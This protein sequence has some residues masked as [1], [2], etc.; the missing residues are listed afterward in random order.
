MLNI[1]CGATTKKITKIHAPK[2][3]KKDQDA[4]LRNIC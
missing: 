1:I 3:M 2:E 4:T